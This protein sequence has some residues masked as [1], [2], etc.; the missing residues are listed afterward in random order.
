[1]REPE[2]K[3]T[4]RPQSAPE[5]PREWYA[6]LETLRDPKRKA[7]RSR[8][9]APSI[10]DP[11]SLTETREMV[12]FRCAAAELRNP[13]PD[14]TIEAIYAARTTRTFGAGSS[15]TLRTT[16]GAKSSRTCSSAAAPIKI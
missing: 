13:F 15:I 9:F 5:G 11:L 14:G 1:M 2:C 16:S 10:L 4:G 6:M 8:I 3:R 12:A 7:I